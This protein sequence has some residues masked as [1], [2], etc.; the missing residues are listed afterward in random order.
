MC[1][2]EADPGEPLEESSLPSRTQGVLSVI[3]GWKS[4][5]LSCL[6]PRGERLGRLASIRV[7]CA[8]RR[9]T[10]VVT[11]GR[12]S[13]R[14]GYGGAAGLWLTGVLTHAIDSFFLGAL[15]THFISLS[16]TK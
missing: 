1:P 15:L 9:R 13:S 4:T 12:F 11:M 3:Q 6:E 5:R 14:F 10:V 2:A 16:T 7:R 8:Q